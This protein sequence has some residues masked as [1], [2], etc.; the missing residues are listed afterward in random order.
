MT[1]TRARQFSRFFIA[2]FALVLAGVGLFN[3]TV[4]PLQYY[5]RATLVEPH[6]SS[7][8]RYQNPGLARNY[9]FDTVVIGTSH[10]ENFTPSRVKHALGGEPLKLAI[11]GSSPREQYLMLELALERGSLKRVLWGVLADS[12]EY[13]DRVVED[14]GPFPWY[15]YRGGLDP[16]FSYLW[17][18][19][20]TRH[21]LAVLRS[22][23]PQALENLNTWYDKYAFGAERV[24]AAWA[25]M[26]V[27][28]TDL[29]YAYYARLAPPWED[30]R[31]VADEYIVAPILEQP[32]VRFDLI[33]PPYTMLEYAND[34]RVHQERFARRLL[35]KAHLIEA[36]KNA[37]HVHLHDFETDSIVSADLSRYKDLSHFDLATTELILREVGLGNRAPLANADAL[38]AAQVLAFIEQRCSVSNLAVCPQRV[39]CGGVRLKRW[40]N[41]GALGAQ[42]LRYSNLPCE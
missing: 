28:W 13:S 42:L 3:F 21:S 30:T 27:R 16:L 38:L 26:G 12:F 31:A 36:F 4:D 23:A 9:P 32:N 40:L 22:P 24:E 14:A 20:T 11:A 34:F 37:G 5:R 8:Q 39:R 29:L 19:D 15:L 25:D 17:S 7:N 2:T 18:F 33:F 41:D 35:L 6:F 1:R 10:M